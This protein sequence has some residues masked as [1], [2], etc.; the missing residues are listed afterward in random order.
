MY[1]GGD[2]RWW[3]DERREKKKRATA[4]RWRALI[5]ADGDFAC[6][7]SKIATKPNQEARSGQVRNSKHCR[8][9]TTLVIGAAIIG[10]R[11]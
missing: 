4:G 9:P 11:R 3:I 7:R 8:S 5:L 2:G 10:K 6:T 1:C